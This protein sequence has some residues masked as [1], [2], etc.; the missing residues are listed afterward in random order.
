M[1]KLEISGQSG[2]ESARGG[3]VFVHAIARTPRSFQKMQRAVGELGFMTLNLG[4]KSRRKSLEVL[5]DDIHSEIQDFSSKI[6]GPLHFVGHS[7]GGLL[8]RIYIAKYAP[9]KLGRVV[10]LGT[11]NGGSEIADFLKDYAL[12]RVLLGPAGQQLGTRRDEGVEAFLPP[13][14]Y[15]VGIIAG[16]RTVDPISS[17]LMLPGP[18]D[19]RV[20]VEN[21]KVS[22][23]ADHIVIAS[24]HPWLPR[25][26]TAI[27]QTISFLRRGKFNC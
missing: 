26:A 24:S 18:N 3:V 7:M 12:Y 20:S 6:D 22:G 17:T 16:N 13:V 27:N 25:N 11:P 4:Y 8:V 19:G 23:M 1:K 21:T 9:E 15:P 2:D 5:A 10:M 14:N